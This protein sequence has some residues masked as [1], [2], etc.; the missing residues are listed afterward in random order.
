[1]FCKTD[2]HA[3]WIGRLPPNCFQRPHILVSPL[4]LSVPLLLRW[5]ALRLLWILAWLPAHDSLNLTF[6]PHC[7]VAMAVRL[8]FV[9]QGD[10]T[11]SNKLL[12]K[13]LYWTCFDMEFGSVQLRVG[14]ILGAENLHIPLS[15]TGR[16]RLRQVKILHRKNSL[17]SLRSS[18]VCT[19]NRMQAFTAG[20]V[21]LR[22]DAFG[23][24]Q[25]IKSTD[26]NAQISPGCWTSDTW[27]WS[28]GKLNC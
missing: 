11:G 12:Q 16:M 7:A 1:M 18:A 17:S 9:F 6:C 5:I 4:S 10:L 24:N 27:A 13:R 3:W 19:M 25:H 20:E 15:M 28:F 21:S 8:R 2:K 22:L 14:Q 23:N 26:A